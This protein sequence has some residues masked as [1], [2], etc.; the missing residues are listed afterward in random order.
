MDFALRDFSDDDYLL[1]IGNPV[2]IGWATAI[3]AA[4]NEG[5]VNLLMWSGKEKG[6][7]EVKA[8]LPVTHAS[9]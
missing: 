3:A 8:I 6:Y 4:Y 5:R 2:F 1:L 9:L 7:R